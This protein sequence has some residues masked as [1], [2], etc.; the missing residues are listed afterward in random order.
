MTSKTRH[1]GLFTKEVLCMGCGHYFPKNKMTVV[2]GV[3]YCED[4][5][6]L[7]KEYKIALDAEKQVVVGGHPVASGDS[8]KWEQAY[9][10]SQMVSLTPERL[11]RLPYPIPIKDLA[12]SLWLRIQSRLIDYFLVGVMVVI[13]DLVFHLARLGKW[14]FGGT[15]VPVSAVQYRT[16]LDP[17][18]LKILFSNLVV[19]KEVFLVVVLVL[20]LYRLFFCVCYRRTLGE[21]FSNIRLTNKEGRYPGRVQMFFKS[22]LTSLGEVPLFLGALVDLLFFVLVKPAATPGEII[23]G[24]RAVNN[25]SWEETARQMVHRL[26]EVRSG[27][28]PVSP[29]RH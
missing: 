4:C 29:A 13:L 2:G 28:I 9:D 20:L 6:S 7:A 21:F 18:G 3:P 10:G 25:S 8:N 26:L 17:Q 22:I 12:P 11:D 24:V 14:F 15:N 16:L 5:R 1:K 23:T 19:F 27:N